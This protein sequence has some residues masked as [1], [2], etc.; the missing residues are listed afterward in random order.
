MRKILN[1]LTT[2]LTKGTTQ[3]QFLK[4]Y[5]LCSSIAKKMISIPA[6]GG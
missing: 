6:K 5:L 1:E 3:L 2:H 4:L